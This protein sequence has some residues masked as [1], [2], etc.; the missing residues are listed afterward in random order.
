LLVSESTKWSPEQ[1]A[2]GWDLFT[3]QSRR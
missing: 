2:R 3:G 1:Q